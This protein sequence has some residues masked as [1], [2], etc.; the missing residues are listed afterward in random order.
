MAAANNPFGPG[1]LGFLRDIERNNNAGWFQAN[2]HRYESEVREPALAFIRAM[3][4]GIRR[5]SPY[6]VAADRKVGGSLMRIYRDVRFSRN[7]KKEST[8]FI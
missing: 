1:L 4:P 5:I 8:P 3:A 6:I 7:G 2:K